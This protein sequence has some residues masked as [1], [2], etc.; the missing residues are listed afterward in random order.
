MYD[1]DFPN[2]LK[3]A[4]EKTGL[5][6]EEVAAETKISRSNISKYETGKLQPDIEKLAIL[7]DFYEVDANWILGTKGKNK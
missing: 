1:K 5:S 7:I 6:Q 4:R 2:R 3:N